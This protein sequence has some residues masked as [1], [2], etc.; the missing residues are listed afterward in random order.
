MTRPPLTPPPLPTRA[1]TW[2]SASAAMALTTARR[3]PYLLLVRQKNKKEKLEGLVAWIGDSTALRVDMTAKTEA[4]AHLPGSTTANHM[5]YNKS[6]VHRLQ[7][8]WV[9]REQ[10]EQDR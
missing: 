7:L 5:P 3:P 2:T 4:G 8:Q 10:I 6:E 1:G 9:L